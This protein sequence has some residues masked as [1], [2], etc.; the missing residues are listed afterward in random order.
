MLF[1]VWLREILSHPL[2]TLIS[3][4]LLRKDNGLAHIKE[5]YTA[6]IRYIG[7]RLLKNS[8]ALHFLTYFLIL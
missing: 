1:F 6:Y 4:T 2:Y 5:P 8:I 3:Q 7:V